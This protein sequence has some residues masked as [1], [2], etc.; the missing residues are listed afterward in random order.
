MTNQIESTQV[1]EPAGENCKPSV[2][3]LSERQKRNFTKYFTQGPEDEC[4]VWTGY[5]TPEGYGRFRFAGEKRGAHQAAYAERNGGFPVGMFVCHHCDNRACVNPK[6]LFI[7]TAADNSADM[8]RKGRQARGDAAGPRLHRESRPR[9]DGHHLRR[10]P[11]LIKKGIEHPHAKRTDAEVIEMR[12]LYESGAY[13]IPQLMIKFSMS[14][15]GV[16]AIVTRRT[17]RHI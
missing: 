17:W 6:H 10:M 13:G 1:N 5:L 8:V 2:I 7:G 16:Y 14:A 3:A 15:G 9:G 4:W 11:E 12:R